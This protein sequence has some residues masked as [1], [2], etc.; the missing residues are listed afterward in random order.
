MGHG[1]ASQMF[2]SGLKVH[3]HPFPA[4]QHQMRQQCLE[5][6]VCLARA[7][8]ARCREAPHDQKPLFARRAAGKRGASQRHGNEQRF[9]QVA[10]VR[11][12]VQHGAARA[13]ALLNQI[14]AARQRLR[15]LVA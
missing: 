12:Q 13:Y 3:Q 15:Q 6:G 14:A 4:F 8:A 10:H 2:H 5:Q 1:A 7:S 11:I 9:R